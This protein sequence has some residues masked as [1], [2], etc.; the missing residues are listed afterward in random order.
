M[1][2]FNFLDWA[3][4]NPAVV[5]F[6]HKDLLGWT[7]VGILFGF[8]VLLIELRL[9]LRYYWNI[10]VYVF[11]NFLEGIHLRKK[12]PVWGYCLDRES[13][14][15]IPI[16]AV[17][18]LDAATKKQ[19]ALTYSNRLGQY[20][21]KPPA[22]KYILRAVKNEYQTPSLLDPENIQ[23]VEVRESYA[24]PVRVG[25]PAERKPQVNLEIQ[26]IEKI[27]PHNPKF[28][29]RRY[30]KTFVFGLSNGFLAL[31]VLAS[32]FSWAVTKEIVY[33]LFLA[34]GL[35]LLFIKIYIL[36]TIGRICR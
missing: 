23:L 16:A 9:P 20:G 27:D 18:L 32:L 12:T 26:P 11:A 8:V 3:G 13:R 36:E 29:L 1:F 17:E 15:V 7:L 6:I 30:V 2:I 10:P 4:S 5:T 21:F 19:A 14:Q 28:L 35:T 22:G 34:V 24:L 33:G 25:S 31:A